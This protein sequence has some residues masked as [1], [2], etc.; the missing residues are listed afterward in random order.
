[1]GLF[2]KLF[3]KDKGDSLVVETPS[4]RITFPPG[5]TIDKEA[6][7][8]SLLGPNN[9]SVSLSL[10]SVKGTGADAKEALA[11]VEA[12]ALSTIDRMKEEDGLQEPT[13]RKSGTLPSGSFVTNIL[14]PAET[15]TFV[16]FVILKGPR[17]LLFSIHEGPTDNVD[18]VG[19]I[20]RC[21]LETKWKS[22]A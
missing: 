22:K 16:N 6:S 4:A 9:Q 12:N 3:G 18:D 10:S 8:L 11:K 7:R 2:G 20:S 5:W 1:M 19:P 14:I 17:S 21:I 15:G 13:D